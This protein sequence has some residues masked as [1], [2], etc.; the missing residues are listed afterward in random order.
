MDKSLISGNPSSSPFDSIKQTRPGGSEFWSARDL[1]PLLGY[2][3]WRRFGESV[4]RATAACE[5]SGHKASDHFAGA[6]KKIVAGKGAAREVADYHL[7]RYAA[8]LVAMNG[9]PRKPEIAAAQTYFAVQTYQQETNQAELSTFR[10]ELQELRTIVTHLAAQP[11]HHSS[12]RFGQIEAVYL[13]PY[14]PNRSPYETELNSF[15]QL[16][17]PLG[18]VFTYAQL[19]AHCRQHPREVVH[20]IFEAALYLGKILPTVAPGIPGRSNQVALYIN[21]VAY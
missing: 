20:W 15:C 4:E 13:P 19:M 9:D 18:Q 10:Q 12:G 14:L 8:Y 3:Q 16:I 5:N 6:G 1:Q 11:T 17:R 7:T 2:D 21:Q